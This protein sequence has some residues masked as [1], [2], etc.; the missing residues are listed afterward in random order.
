ML[1]IW[2][3]IVAPAIA[4]AFA[5]FGL[6]GSGSAGLFAA[7][8]IGLPAVL[9]TGVALWLRCGLHALTFGLIAAL[10]GALT[11]VSLALW[12]SERISS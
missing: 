2:S 7:V 11:W 6:H 10:V 3:V 8:F 5:L 9:A 4:T 12:L 1:V